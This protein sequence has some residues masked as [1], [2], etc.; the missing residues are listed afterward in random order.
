MQTQGFVQR[1]TRPNS[2][3]SWGG[4]GV[5]GASPKHQAVQQHTLWQPQ[6][7]GREKAIQDIT[8]DATGQ[9]LLTQFLQA[10]Q[11]VDEEESVVWFGACDRVE[12]EVQLF[13]IGCVL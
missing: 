9:C 2:P 3:V 10:G 7:R 6:T 13:Q 8:T 5:M 11:Q 4:G 12:S 1:C